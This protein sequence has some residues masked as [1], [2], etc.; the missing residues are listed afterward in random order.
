MKYKHDDDKQPVL[1]LDFKDDKVIIEYDGDYH[2][3]VV[4][5]DD[6]ELFINRR[7]IETN[8][9]QKV[10]LTDFYQQVVVI[11]R[12]AKRIGW[13]GAKIGVEGAKLGLYAVGCVFKLLSPNY[14]SDD[15]ERDVEFEAEKI[16]KKAEELEKQAEIIEKMV[17]DL[18]D[19]AYE[20]KEEIP[21]L[22]KL[23]WL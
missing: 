12:E 14:D 20:L 10:L 5:D 1:S 7:H 3:K 16:E 23:K 9:N 17:E 21:E 22:Q 6:Y 8:A 15:L 13:E 19:M 2:D 18:D 11:K 4:I